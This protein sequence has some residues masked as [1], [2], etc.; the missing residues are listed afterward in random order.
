M[1][2]LSHLTLV[3]GDVVCRRQRDMVARKRHVRLSLPCIAVCFNYFYGRGDLVWIY[4]RAQSYEPSR[5]EPRG[6]N[7]QA[8]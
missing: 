2:L 3:Y 4:G 1:V 6:H 8:G 5:G 7:G